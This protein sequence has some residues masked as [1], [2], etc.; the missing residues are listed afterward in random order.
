MLFTVDKLTQRIQDVQKF[1]TVKLKHEESHDSIAQSLSQIGSALKDRKLTLGICG[2]SPELV[3]ALKAAL[4]L[5]RS[6]EHFQIKVIPYPETVCAQPI[7]LISLKVL[8][9]QILQ[10]SLTQNSTL[11]IGRHSGC[12][13]VLPFHFNRVSSQHA[14]I[15]WNQ[16]IQICDRNSRNGTFVN[17]NRIEGCHDLQ[18]SDQV[19]FA[20]PTPTD[21]TPVLS[22]EAPTESRSPQPFEDCHVVCIVRK[23]EPVSPAERELIAQVSQNRRC[24][25]IVDVPR[26]ETLQTDSIEMT[27]LALDLYRPNQATQATMVEIGAQPD[28]V[29]FSQKLAQ[30]SIEE[31]ILQ[32]L[33]P[34]LIQ[35]IER[36]KQILEQQESTIA[37]EIQQIEQDLATGNADLKEQVRKAIKKANDDRD[38]FFRQAKLDFDQSKRDMLDKMR[39]GSIS[40][41]VT[42]QIEPLT[43][44]VV[45]RSGRTYL[46]LQSKTSTTPSGLNQELN[47]FCRSQLS[48]WGTQEWQNICSS[49]GEGGWIALLQRM[50][51]TLKVIPSLRSPDELKQ[52]LHPVDLNR[53]LEDSAIECDCEVH[54]KTESAISYIFK[55]T[56]G[57][58]Q[59]LVSMLALVGLALGSQSMEGLKK[60]PAILAPLLIG[61]IVFL[62]YSYH[63]NQAARLQEETEKLKEKTANYYQELARNLTERL[64]Q[65]I[66]FK[67][68]SENQRLKEAIEAANEQFNRY[69]GD[70]DKKQIQDRSS[71]T[72]KKARQMEL[73]RDKLELDRFSTPN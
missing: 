46:Q 58:V 44:T 10:S 40:S 61:V 21:K 7:A 67:L 56:R 19:T 15:R 25:V 27:P 38:K 6:L 52:T 36:I 47:Y 16:T 45:Q 17:G 30:L 70:L 12:Q 60:N 3:Q 28:L 1:L 23:N 49:Y 51:A 71:L 72:E 18:P 14:E 68:D 5:E 32:Q 37:Q 9:Q 66:N 41:K 39:K 62:I 50:I 54:Y 24:F 59:G 13:I 4:S 65:S 35:Q 42:E 34:K 48:Q 31:L 8:D 55:N 43:A 64:A 53:I 26:G 33:S 69:L 73:K 11:L 22:I 2:Q 20:Y 29:E 57:Q 63:Q